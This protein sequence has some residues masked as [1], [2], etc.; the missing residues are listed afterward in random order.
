MV[1]EALAHGPSRTLGFDALTKFVMVDDAPDLH[2]LKEACC[3]MSCIGSAAYFLGMELGGAM[4]ANMTAIG[5][6]ELNKHPW[7]L[8][9]DITLPR[10]RRRLHCTPSR[11]LGVHWVLASDVNLFPPR[12]MAEGKLILA[13]LHSMQP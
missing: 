4:D 3:G 5:H 13:V 2:M 6:L 8:L 7:P 1:Y 10:D 12:A 9:G 11:R